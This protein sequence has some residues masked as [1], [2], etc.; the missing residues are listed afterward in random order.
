MPRWEA[1]EATLRG[2]YDAETVGETKAGSQPEPESSA[3]SGLLRDHGGRSTRDP[4][5]SCQVH[6]VGE[7]ARQRGCGGGCGATDGGR[8]RPR[9]RRCRR[10][11]WC[12][13]T[14]DSSRRQRS[15]EDSQTRQGHAPPRS[16][17]ARGHGPR[18]ADTAPHDSGPATG[19]RRRPACR[20][21]PR[22]ADMPPLCARNHTSAPRPCP[23]PSFDV[24]RRTTV[25]RQWPTA[26]A[27]HSRR[28]PRP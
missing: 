27:R 26:R 10:I 9:H 23:R 11:H 6:Q 18:A 25:P 1:T 8:R 7:Q 16:D 22:R 3:T 17:S 19:I 24:V 21:R 20:G 12:S 28:G 5:S 2:Q 15:T 14:Q 4:P 13:P